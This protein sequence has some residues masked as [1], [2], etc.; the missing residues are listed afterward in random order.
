MGRDARR[1]SLAGERDATMAAERPKEIV[2]TAVESPPAGWRV[3]GWVL[4]SLAGLAAGVVAV[5]LAMWI[6]VYVVL[7]DG[8]TG[9]ASRGSLMS[10]SQLVTIAS[11]LV[12]VALLVAYVVWFYQCRRLAERHSADGRRIVRHWTLALWRVLFVGSIVLSYLSLGQLTVAQPDEV[13]AAELLAMT[14]FQ[15]GFAAIRLVSLAFLAAGIVV[16]HRRMRGLVDG[17]HQPVTLTREQ[18]YWSGRPPDDPFQEHWTD[19]RNPVP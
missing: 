13:G 4:V 2:V 19:Y 17:T 1:V 9:A 16:V 15:I 12:I 3:A 18:A 11:G 10:S 6:G 14:R 5:R 7:H 8:R